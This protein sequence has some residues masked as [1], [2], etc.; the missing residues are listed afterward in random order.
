MDGTRRSSLPSRTIDR[1]RPGAGD[2]RRA[3]A[4]HYDPTGPGKPLFGFFAAM[5][6][7]EREKTQTY[8]EAV[9]SAHADFAALQQRDHSPV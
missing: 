2:A 6:E 3:A 4:R 9:E 1:A 5:A 8:P 7:T